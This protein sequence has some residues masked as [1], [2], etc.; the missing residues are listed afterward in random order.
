MLHDV[1][2]ASTVWAQRLTV[3]EVLSVRSCYDY[4]ALGFKQPVSFGKQAIQRRVVK[5]FYRFYYKD[6]IRNPASIPDP[7]VKTTN[8]PK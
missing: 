6:G 8:R 4:F 1:K 5:M 7:F 2:N 3:A